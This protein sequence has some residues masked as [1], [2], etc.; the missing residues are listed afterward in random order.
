MFLP[1][2]LTYLHLG[3]QIIDEDWTK[4]IKVINTCRGGKSTKI[5]YSSKC[6]ITL[7]KFYLSTIKR[8]QSKNPKYT[9]VKVKSSSFKMYSK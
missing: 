9:Q 1:V 4:T 5:F 2:S 8:Y 6:T 7:M 3:I